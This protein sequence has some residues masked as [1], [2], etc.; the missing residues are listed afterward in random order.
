MY[1]DRQ[2]K[3]AAD[4]IIHYLMKPKKLQT[5]LQHGKINNRDAEESANYLEKNCEYLTDDEMIVVQETIAEVL[6]EKLSECTAEVFYINYEHGEDRLSKE[7]QERSGIQ[8]NFMKITMLGKVKFSLALQ[9][10]GTITFK[11]QD[12]NGDPILVFDGNN[13]ADN[14]YKTLF[15]ENSKPEFPTLGTT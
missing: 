14:L 8:K 6:Q 13:F 10:D 5:I 12:Q 11:D 1:T 9:K 3:A 4:F 7:I 15:P 2:I